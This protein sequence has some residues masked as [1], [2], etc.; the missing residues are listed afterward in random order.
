MPKKN[1]GKDDDWDFLKSLEQQSKSQ[2]SPTKE[3]EEEITL[4]HPKFPAVNLQAGEAAVDN[5][6]FRNLGSWAENLSSKQTTPPTVPVSQLYA[7]LKFPFGVVKTYDASI[8]KFSE[9]ARDSSDLLSEEK[10]HSLR[11]A[12]EVHRQTRRHIQSLI[13]P[14]MKMID[15]VQ[16]IEAKVMELIEG[17]GLKAGWGFPTGCSLNSCAAHYTPNYGD[18]TVLKESDIMKIDFG[19]HHKGHIID[20]AFTV[21]WDSKFDSL[22]EA[23][24]EGT[25][26]G[27]SLAGPDAIFTEI[28]KGIQ[29]VIQSYEFE[30]RGKHIPI[31]C[32]KNLHGHTIGPYKIHAGKSLPIVP[33]GDRTRMEEGD[34]FAIET[35]A[36]TGKG[37]VNDKGEC[38][39]YSLNPDSENKPKPR[40]ASA[41][42]LYAQLRNRFGTLPF[43][44]RWIDDMGETRH[45]L[46][47]KNLVDGG[48]VIDYPPLCDKDGC[49]TSQSE[50]TV[51]LK[52]SGKEILSVGSDY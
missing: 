5:S 1:K 14:G 28:G 52:P 4:G 18:N 48:Y 25:L 38:S 9:N 12:A 15:I 29:E 10:L 23:T 50:H 16:R 31:L 41:S 19:V 51:L 30:D 33:N 17:Q 6:R 2:K 13:Q 27:L 45:H 42:K 20:S 32:V 40:L 11:T 34:L 35:F 44:R 47:L 8:H 49:F 46:G 7:P 43:C 37:Y 22:I 21:A 39:H 26:R 3:V 36:S 24:K